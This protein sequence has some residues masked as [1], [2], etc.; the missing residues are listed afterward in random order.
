MR[1]ERDDLAAELTKKEKRQPRDGFVRR[2]FVVA[3]VTLFAI[4]LPI[5]L[6]VAWAHRTVLNTDTYVNTVKPIAKDP[7]VT[8]AVSREITDQVYASLDPQAAIKDALPPRAA[9]RFPG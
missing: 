7:A 6:T 2:W 4:L 3:L 5:T 9:F 8:A 1:S